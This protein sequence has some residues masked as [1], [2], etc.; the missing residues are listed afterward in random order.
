[1]H[2]AFVSLAH[3]TI[4]ALAA[5]NICLPMTKDIYVTIS[6]VLFL[7]VGALHG[8]RALYGWELIIGE[9]AIPVS[10]S[11]I[12]SLILLFLAYTSLYSLR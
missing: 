2:S 5:I 3:D 8:V 1:M 9:V 12:A 7:A 4:F 11:A 6:G 10:V